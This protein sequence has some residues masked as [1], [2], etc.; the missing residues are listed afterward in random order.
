MYAHQKM[1][2]IKQGLLL[3]ESLRGITAISAATLCTRRTVTKLSN[4]FSVARQSTARRASILWHLVHNRVVNPCYTTV[5]SARPTNRIVVR[6]QGRPS[7]RENVCGSSK[8]ST[9]RTN[10]LSNLTTGTLYESL[11]QLKACLQIWP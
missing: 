8:K 7:T 3:S 9:Y 1:L 4:M 11:T 6:M 2:Y 10:G 5:S